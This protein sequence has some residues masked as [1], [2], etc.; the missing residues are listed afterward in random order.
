MANDRTNS[1]DVVAELPEA[2]G[3]LRPPLPVLE[4]M[5]LAGRLVPV[6]DLLRNLLA[7]TGIRIYRV[8][9]VHAY[10]T[11]PRR[12]VG[13]QII[14]SRRELLPMPRVRDLN[15]VRRNLLA[16][17]LTEEGDIIVDQI[18]ARYT[19]DDLSCRTPDNI[20]PQIPRTSLKTVE[21]WYEIQENRASQPSPPI[22][23]FSPPV[24][25]PMLSRGGLA[26]T[27]VLTKQGEDRGRRGE[28]PGVTA[29]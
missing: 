22:R 28:A 13:D 8:F 20:D 5:T 3:Q 2:S 26:W 24:A 10:W 11:G 4:P 12:G 14:A 18:S 7:K 21:F 29:E 16:A 25:T 23:R 17:G 6:A 19:E 15:A 1:G 27:V 9:I